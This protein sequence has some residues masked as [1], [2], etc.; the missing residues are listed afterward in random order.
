MIRGN[1]MILVL[2]KHLS[3]YKRLKTD[4]FHENLTSCFF[5]LLVYQAHSFRNLKNAKFW[6]GLVSKNDLGLLRKFS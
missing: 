4:K 2:K 3:V 1:D 5:L 6:Y